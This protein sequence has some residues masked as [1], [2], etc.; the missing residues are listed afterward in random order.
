[1]DTYAFYTGQMFTA[2][3]WLG[4]H[5][6]ERGAVF[7]VFAPNA[8]GVGVIGDFNHWTET[9]MERV[10]DGNFYECTVPN[11]K[12][13]MRYKLRIHEQSGR[14]LDRSDPF[15]FAAEPRPQ[16]SSII[17]SQNLFLFSDGKWMRS[18]SVRKDKPL[19]IYEL[20]LGSWRNGMDYRTIAEPLIEHV[21][22]CG[23]N[24]IEIM[25]ICEYPSDTSWG[26][27]ATG[28]FCPTSRY[29][30]PDD[31][32]YLINECHKCGIGVLLDI[33]LVHFA[34]DDF[35][36]ADFDG[37]AL[38]EYPH[39]SVGYNEWG[40]KNFNHYR[41]EVRS[42]LQSSVMYWLKEFHFDGVRMDAVRNLL[43]WQGSMERGENK[44]A[45]DFLRGM[46][47]GLK[48]E[49]PDVM[50]IA[51]D[52]STYDGITKPVCEGGLGFDYK[53]DMGW[54]NDTLAYFQGDT[55]QRIRDYHKL[56]FSMMYFYNE[57]YLLPLSHDE[58]VHGKAAILQKMNGQY[59]NKFPQARAFYL[60]MYAHPGK[61]LSFMGNEIAQ[62]R[63]WDEKRE[64]D[65]DIL[66]YPAHDS[67]F[68]Y[69]KQ[70]GQIYQA[71]PALYEKDFD[72]DGF[73][74]LDCKEGNCVY[75]FI[76]RGKRQTVL[77][78]FN[79]ADVICDNY[80][81]KLDEYDAAS[82]ILD[83]N[84]ERFGGTLSETHKQIMIENGRF[85]LNLEPFSGKLFMLYG[86]G[87]I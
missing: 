37:S 72:R 76:R 21:K 59:E 86:S 35:G 54:M 39:P 67:F 20:H 4:A 79:F 50:L 63:E 8:A 51:E 26:Y 60:Y 24:Y 52:S 10:L 77:A 16:T 28:F 81:L 55:A 9:K 66:K 13:G 46:N 5:L 19:N 14:F 25:P 47:R 34:V 57:S 23:Y 78:I 45:I 74:W 15:G 30:T 3:H 44:G 61:K 84:W 6:T 32:K 65:W 83:S 87:C 11:A 12:D 2:Y 75:S 49:L 27:Q 7:R 42:F 82:P 64:Q 48:K 38:Y 17:A 53:W 56:P 18:R 68:A 41:G 31:L 29:G 69:M 22:T 73:L 43:Y 62:L 80:T 85:T 71:A 1:M 33:E 58:V 40:S 36:L 70:L